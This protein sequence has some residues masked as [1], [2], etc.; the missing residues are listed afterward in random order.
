MS[1]ATELRERQQKLLADARA[2]LDE[3][4]DDTQ[5]GRASEIEAEHDAIMSEYDRLEARASRLEAIEARE[6]AMNAP[7]PRRPVGDD[8]VAPGRTQPRAATA[9][10]AFRSYLLH[11]VEGMLPEQRALLMRPQA[12]GRAQATTPGASG[13]FLVPTGFQSELVRSLKAWGPMLDPG[14]TRQIETAGGETINWPTNNDTGSKARIVGENAEVVP[15]PTGGHNVDGDLVFANKTLGA[16]KYGTGLIR[17]SSELAQDSAI[18][19]EAVIRDTMA[20]RL[21]RGVNEHLTVGIGT[22]QPWGILTRSTEGYEAP[23]V[24]S[25]AAITFDALIELFHAVDPAYRADPSCRWMFADDT[26]KLLRKIK[27]LE[28]NYIWQP[29]N[30]A[31]EQPATI[32]GKP[33]SINQAMPTVAF[34]AKTVVFGAFSRYVVR[35]VREL[36]VARLNERYAEFDQ[37]AFIGFARFDGELLDT[38][39]V[40]HLVHAEDPS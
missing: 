25:V 17:V 37:F 31:T 11:G 1:A 24:S 40:K 27:D 33:Y 20:E 2:K 5:E 38:A 15:A 21:G 26:L 32:L 9:E 35:R 28:G 7:D 14:V 34:E 3:I 6:A 23:N 12:E 18:N 19:L 36:S 8:R 10:D 39:A 16:F 22:T 4:T 30:A 13:G 29:A